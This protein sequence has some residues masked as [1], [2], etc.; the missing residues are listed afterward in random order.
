ME[1]KYNYHK[2]ITKN[3]KMQLKDNIINQINEPQIKG[4]NNVYM[5]DNDFPYAFYDNTIHKV[6]WDLNEES[7]S[8]QEI[9]NI[10]KE[11]ILGLFN[12][13]Y[14]WILFQNK[15][16]Y[17]SIPNLSHYHVF[18]RPKSAPIIDKLTKIINVTINNNNKN[19]TI[20]LGKEFR[21]FYQPFIQINNPYFECP[22]N[23]NCQSTLNNFMEGFN[24]NDNTKEMNKTTIIQSDRLL[25]SIESRLND[26]Q[27]D[28]ICHVTNNTI[29]EGLLDM[30][31]DGPNY[32][33]PKDNST[34]RFEKWTCLNFPEMYVVHIVYDGVKISQ[35][36]FL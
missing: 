34:I 26:D 22:N 11:H 5:L 7:L 15:M 9:E 8:H 25:D 14:D 28:F 19:D 24:Q 2:K 10:F 13:H 12:D 32:D 3:K 21:S 20:K 18:F 33:K 29:F 16:V 36:N 1:S 35:Y 6:L 4:H 17:R 30:L 23:L 31:C 27:Y